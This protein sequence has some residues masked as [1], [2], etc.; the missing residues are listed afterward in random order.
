MKRNKVVIFIISVIFLLCLVWILFPNK[1]TE[2]KSFTYEIKENNDE[3]IIEVNYQF[4]INT[5]ILVMQLLF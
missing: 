3:L 5:G 1:S 4:T 2:V